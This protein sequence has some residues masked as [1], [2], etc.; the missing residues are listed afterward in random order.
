MRF[1]YILYMLPHVT[2]HVTA[3]LLYFAI[4]FYMLPHVT[5]FFNIHL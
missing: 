5:A 2:G 3:N 1:E 4:D